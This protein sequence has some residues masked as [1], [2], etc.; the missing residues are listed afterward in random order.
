MNRVVN[1]NF[2][3]TGVLGLGLLVWIL[4]LYTR[5]IAIPFSKDAIWE[6][7]TAI[8]YSTPII[9]W[10]VKYGWKFRIFKGWLVLVP[11]LS[12]TWE[13]QLVSTW[14]NPETK[15]PRGKIKAFL[16]IK[17]SLLSCSCQLLTKESKSWS[18]SAA[19]QFA[20]D[21]ECQFLDFSYSNEP[22]VTVQNRSKAHHGACTLDIV[23]KPER[24]L[25]GKYWT[26]RETKGEIDLTFKSKEY[27]ETFDA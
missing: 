1:F 24:K 17:Q 21:G 15:K 25:V 27:R 4:V 18:R 16:V 3:A 11:N 9:V 13:G 8:G 12:G 23:T 6:I 14:I 2:A 19:I 10:F 22:R 20:P 26:D 7:P 5:G